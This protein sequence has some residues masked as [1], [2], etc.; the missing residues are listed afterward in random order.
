MNDPFCGQKDFLAMKRRKQQSPDS[1]FTLVELLVVIAIIG[2]LVALLLP[3]VQAAREAARR[4]SCVNNVKNLAL[5]CLNYESSHKAL[6][7]SR[8]FDYWDS[9]TWTQYVLPFIEQQAVYDMYWTLPNSKWEQPDPSKATSNSP[10]GPDARMRQA[11]NTPISLFYCPSDITPIENETDTTQ[12]GTLRGNYRA[13]VGSTDM[14]GN[15]LDN[16]SYVPLPQLGDLLGAMG[17]KK[18]VDAQARVAPNKLAELSDGTSTTLLISEG[19]SPTITPGWGGPIGNVIYGN[20]GGSM[21]SA[22]HPPNTSEFDRPIGP[23]PGPVVP[24]ADLLDPQYPDTC[25]KISD[26]PGATAPGG[27]TARVFARSYHPG[28]VNAAMADGSVS[29]ATDDVETLVWRALGTGR[30]SDSSNK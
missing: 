2:V 21:F 13:C 28:G 7:P 15:R 17:V 4:S 6:P 22:F 16:T 29:F 8:K 12:F 27:A 20:M 11:R 1:G 18:P 3:A 30:Y 10:I 14:Y 23:C 5:G 25:R 26:H 24:P 9:Y 19:I